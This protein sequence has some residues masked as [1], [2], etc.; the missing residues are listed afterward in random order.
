MELFQQCVTPWGLLIHLFSANACESVYQAGLPNDP[1]SLVE[2]LPYFLK[3]CVL[4]LPF[5]YFFLTRTQSFSRIVI[6][7]FIL[8]LLTHPIVFLVMPILFEHLGL[9]YLQYLLLA[10]T[11]APLTEA[12]VL[13]YVFKVEAPTAIRAALVANLLSWGIGVFW[14]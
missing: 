13:H 1:M 10:E 2:Y 6:I 9:N 11:F 5:Y 4:E 8:N 12:I 14:I 3:T 7:N